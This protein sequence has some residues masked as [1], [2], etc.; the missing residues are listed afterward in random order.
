MSISLLTKR[1]I[2]KSSYNL[3]CPFDLKFFRQEES[4][5]VLKK[6]VEA[7]FRDPKIVDNVAE[8]LEAHKKSN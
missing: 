2:M 6:S 4:L 1:I 3:R 5:D 7:R 8:M